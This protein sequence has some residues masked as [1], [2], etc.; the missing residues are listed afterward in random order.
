MAV[1]P[2]GTAAVSWINA[3]NV[4][5]T[6]VFWTDGYTVKNRRW[7]GSGWSDGNFVA[8]GGDVSAACYSAGGA[9]HLRVYCTFEDAVTEWCSDDSGNS[10]YAGSFTIS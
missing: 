3:Q 8:K 2:V 6:Q 1:Y 7:D 10:W 5:H 4:Q 9:A